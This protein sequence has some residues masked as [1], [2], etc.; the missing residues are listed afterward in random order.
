MAITAEPLERVFEFGALRFPDPNP[1]LSNQEVRDMLATQ[2]PE[3]ANATITETVR[4][5]KRVILL[6]RSIGRKG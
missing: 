1:D 6:E 5:G 3:L 4:A 2:Y